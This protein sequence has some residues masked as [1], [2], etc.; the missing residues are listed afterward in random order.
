LDGLDRQF[1]EAGL[2]Q[3]PAGAIKVFLSN[4]NPS[5]LDPAILTNR[6]VFENGRAHG[7]VTKDATGISFEACPVELVGLR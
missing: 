2:K 7:C 4:P 5:N 6:K 1:P 3:I